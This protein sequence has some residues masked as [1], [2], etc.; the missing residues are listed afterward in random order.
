MS[1]DCYFSGRKDVCPLCI[2]CKYPDKQ[3]MVKGSDV[4]CT[5]CTV[6]CYPCPRYLNCCEISEDNI[7]SASEQPLSNGYNGEVKQG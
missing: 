4:L 3:E 6:Y 7:R 2:S 5:T 1:S